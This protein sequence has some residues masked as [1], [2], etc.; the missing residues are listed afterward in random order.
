MSR[1]K[2]D[3][4]NKV[5]DMQIGG[6]HYKDMAIQP[7]DFIAKNHIPFREGNAIKYIVRHRHKNG[8]QDIEK[9]IH[10][11]QMILADYQNNGGNE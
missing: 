4:L 7:I 2:A 5:L 3:E 1:E 8:Q 10:Y 9:A 6:M 11:L